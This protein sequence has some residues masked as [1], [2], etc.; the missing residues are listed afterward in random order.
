[1][2][3]ARI[4]G[5]GEGASNLVHAQK[6]AARSASE[7]KMNDLEAQHIYVTALLALAR[8]AVSWMHQRESSRATDLIRA[9]VSGVKTL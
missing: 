8:A 4:V 1:M 5:G 6:R 7:E 2:E 9:H 3:A